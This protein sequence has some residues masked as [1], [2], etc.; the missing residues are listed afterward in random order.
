MIGFDASPN[1][2][3]AVR[4]VGKL[5]APRDGQVTLISVVELIAPASRAPLVGGIRATVAREVRRIN[6]ER[7]RAA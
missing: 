7:S 5:V 4:L 1:A 3:R 6:T 2:L